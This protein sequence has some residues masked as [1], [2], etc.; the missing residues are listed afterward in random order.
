MTSP[1]LPVVV[2]VPLYT[3]RLSA[4]DLMS[5]K[6]TVRVLGHHDLAIAC[7][8]GLDLSPLD[9]VVAPARPR[10]VRFPAEYF[11]GVEGYNRLMLSERFYARFDDYRYLLICQTDAF[12][13]A[14][15]LHY[16]CGKGYDYIGAPWMASERTAWN[17]ALFKLNNAF[18]K[19][20]KSDEYLFKVG[21]G[22]FSLRRVAMMRR[23]VR[24]QREHIERGLRAPGDRNHHVEDQY[25]SL[26]A[27]ARIPEMKIPAYAE[28]VDFCIDRRPRL[29][30][31]LNGGRLPFACHGFGKRNVRRFWRPILAA[32]EQSSVGPGAIFQPRAP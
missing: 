9:E 25:F 21:N 19:K 2:V 5:L 31:E 6:R 13:F 1:Q 23:I 28:A 27:P 18:R 20:K 4:E 14:D 10:V 32:A 24:E 7:P 8:E 17:R 29:A 12:V 26:V 3:T 22:G 30:L 11:A 16:W 15:R